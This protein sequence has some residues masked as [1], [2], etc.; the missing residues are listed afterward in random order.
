VV[1]DELVA[2]DSAS[3]RGLLLNASAA[4]VLTSLD[5]EAPLTDVV[6]ALAAELGVPAEVLRE[7]VGR[8]VAGFVEWGLVEPVEP[9]PRGQ[10]PMTR[11]GADHHEAAS[12]SPSPGL[13]PIGGSV[14]L[15]ALDGR[16]WLLERPGLPIGEFAVRLCSDSAEV[17]ARLPRFLTGFADLGAQG[18]A[19][20]VGRPERHVAV[21]Q[22]EGDEAFAVAVD[23]VVVDE[24]PDAAGVVGAALYRLDWLASQS[25]DQLA[26]HAGAVERRGRAVLL[27]GFSGGG[28]STLTAAFT[29]R[30]WGYLS[31]EVALVDPASLSVHPYPKDL[32]LGDGSLERLGVSGGVDVGERKRKLPPGELGAVSSGGQVSLVVVLDAQPLFA[33]P[34]RAGV[35]VLRPA[36]AMVA[37]MPLVFDPSLSHEGNLEALAGLCERVP[38]VRLGRAPLA[39]MVDTI[40]EML[41]TGG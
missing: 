24:A 32:D 31:D 16:H 2:F 7:D 14:G 38:V 25:E 1:D 4:L 41:A 8:A 13:V 17:A 23:G 30:G 33:A 21:L 22:P 36:E 34:G 37:L 35:L 11:G 26:F 10:E 20:R 3:R 9:P 19:R 12:S 6:G 5:G 18:A 40:E 39:A 15:A 27:A 29:Q 28:K